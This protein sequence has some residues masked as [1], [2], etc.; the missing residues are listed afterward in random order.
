MLLTRSTCTASLIVAG[1]LCA[2]LFS[3]NSHCQAQHRRFVPGQEL[4]RFLGFGHGAGYHCS[5]PGQNTDYYNPYSAH[6]SLLISANEPYNGIAQ[7]YSNFDSTT[8]PHSSYT[9]QNQSQYSVFD[10]LPG[11]TVRPS[12]EP[13]VDRT[14]KKRA[15]TTFEPDLDFE[16]DADFESG[17]DFESDSDLDSASGFDSPSTLGESNQFDGNEMTSDGDGGFDALKDSFD[18][19]QADEEQSLK[20]DAF[21]EDSFLD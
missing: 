20:T 12:F 9:G 15:A 10:S 6:N 21:G 14:Q 4:G 17:S 2:M 16:T 11:Q 8:V 7:G 5:N 1:V 18:D 13:A 19:V 3:P